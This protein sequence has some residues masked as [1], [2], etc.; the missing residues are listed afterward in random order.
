MTT[1]LDNP[2][3]LHVISYNGCEGRYFKLVCRNT[4]GKIVN[5]YPDGNF[6]RFELGR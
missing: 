6:F 1:E 2:I 4:E 5:I 3:G